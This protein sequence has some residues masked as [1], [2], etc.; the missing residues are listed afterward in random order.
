MRTTVDINADLLDRLR[1]LAD[2]EGISLKD[3]LNRAI[4]RGLTTAPATSREP[5]RLPS[6]HIGIPADWDAKRI[7]QTLYDEEDERQLRIVSGSTR[8]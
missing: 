4:T 1:T 5:Y 6:L 8:A 3:A 2:E 7:K